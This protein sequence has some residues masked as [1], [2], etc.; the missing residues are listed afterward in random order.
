VSTLFISHSSRDSAMVREIERR[1]AERNHSSVNLDVD[2]EKGIVGGQ[3][4]E[5]TLYRK[6]RACRAVVV[7][8]TD[9]HLAPQWCFAEIALARMEGKHVVSLLADPLAAGARL[10]AILDAQQFIDLRGDVDQGYRR[11]WGALNA[12]DL[13]GV[14]G[15]WNVREAP[16]LGLNAYDER[17]APVFFGRDQEV[18]A[19]LELLARGSPGLVTV[20]GASGSGKSSVARAGIVPRLRLAPERWLVG[21]PFAELAQA[22][23]DAFQRQAPGSSSDPGVRASIDGRQALGASHSRTATPVPA[24]TP[25]STGADERLKRLL[26]HLEDL[27][28]LPP[29]GAG[30]AVQQFLALSLGD[31]RRTC[32]ERASANG[33]AAANA[34]PV[35]TG[36]TARAAAAHSHRIGHLLHRADTPPI[37]PA[38]LLWHEPMHPPVVDHPPAHP[39]ARPP[40][41]PTDRPTVRP[42][43]RPSVRDRREGRRLA[44]PSQGRIGWRVSE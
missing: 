11:L 31:L 16:Y 4:W 40:D 12:L 28:R 20:L 5:G 19:G 29:A 10:P 32:A 33:A 18:G 17:H 43:V 1:L 36:A 23:A 35:D 37:G 6:L 34:V 27:Q 3:R 38:H 22:F 21:G 24:A 13:V 7:V 14:Q 25:P 30:P 8:C 2:P 42:S 39:P 9:H 26:K 44:L 41:R 15:E